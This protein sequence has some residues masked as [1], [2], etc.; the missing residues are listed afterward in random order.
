MAAGAS[1]S[2][3]SA[4]VAG[5]ARMAV[6]VFGVRV[7][8]AGCALLAQV[9]MARAMGPA[10]YGIFAAV[11]VWTALLGHA[12]TWG[13]S[14]A[15]S[16][17]LP[18]Y[19][20][21]GTAARGR[22]FLVFGAAL[23]LAAG[24]LLAGTGAALLAL[25]P[26]LV[27]P[28]LRGPLLLGA[29]VLP[30]VALQDFC[31]GVARG[32]TW[33]LLAIAPPYLL[34]QA[35]LAAAMLAAVAAGAP[36]LAAT[37]VA[38]MLAATALSLAL[39]GAALLG[40]LARLLPPG[41]GAYPWR[42]WMRTAL[43]L[44]LVDLAG[45]GFNFADVLVLGFLLPPEAVGLYF[46]ATRLVQ[47]VAFVAYAASAVAAPRFAE[48]Q[49]RG[50]RAGLA[51]LVRHWARLTLLAV[52]ATGLAI[53]AAAPVLLG[54]FG[55][56]FRAGLP[57]LALLVAGHALAAAFGP[58]EDVLSMLGAERLCAALTGALLVL[59]VALMLALVPPLGVL[60]AALAAA[61]VVALRGL[62]LALAARRRLGLATAAIGPTRPE[63]A[64]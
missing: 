16:R 34:R 12:S 55:A 9:L 7:A 17:F 40:R 20:A 32:Q 36:P 13:L 42:G 31:E 3:A 23:S 4:S 22:G 52:L 48:A 60:G 35:L 1:L 62:L 53:L 8:A 21:T 37:A 19:R 58:A 64:P 45:S 6:A 27:E 38:C 5:L 47:V 10:E 24:T 15:A 30:L 50:D 28:G 41:P 59:T 46:A 29:L 51:R 25:A 49:A 11:W 33:T 56:D 44:A 61:L 26:G 57:L 43:P 14:Q 39:Q 2:D 54:L 63:A 18:E